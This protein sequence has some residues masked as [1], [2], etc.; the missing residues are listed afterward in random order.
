MSHYLFCLVEVGRWVP[1]LE[2]QSSE[3][4]EVAE[5]VKDVRLD[6]VQS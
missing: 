1:D 2:E 4:D 5:V 6:P 3:V